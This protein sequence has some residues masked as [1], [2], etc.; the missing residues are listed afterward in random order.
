MQLFR[1]SEDFW[2]GAFMYLTPSPASPNCAFQLGEEQFQNGLQMKKSFK[3]YIL[4]PLFV[5]AEWG[6]DG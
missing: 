1:S 2:C 3:P 5:F 4:L 6:K